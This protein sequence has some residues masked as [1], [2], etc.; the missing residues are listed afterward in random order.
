MTYSSQNT[1]W[2]IY[3]R[4]PRL[5]F[6]IHT[7]NYGRGTGGSPCNHLHQPQSQHPNCDDA[8]KFMTICLLQ[9]STKLSGWRQKYYSQTV[10]QLQSIYFSFPFSWSQCA[11]VYLPRPPTLL[12]L[13]S[14]HSWLPRLMK[15]RGPYFFA[16]FQTHW[17]S[18]LS[19]HSKPQLHWYVHQSAGHSPISLY[20]CL[21]ADA[22]LSWMCASCHLEVHP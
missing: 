17:L 12:S 2:A 19:S 15:A 14:L 5:C 1:Q 8:E 16:F 22:A 3:S 7:E 11:C 10:F 13:P 18:L 20:S 9:L 21:Y 6:Y 4:D